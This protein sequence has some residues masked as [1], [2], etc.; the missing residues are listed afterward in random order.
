MRKSAWIS[1]VLLTLSLSACKGGKISKDQCEKLIDH[2]VDVIM[3]QMGGGLSDDIKKDA[4]KQAREK[5]AAQMDKCT[6]E[7]TTAQYDC[8]MKADSLDAI[9]KCGDE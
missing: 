3:K 9:M 4:A 7:V 8:A 6:D 2:S 1:A 5:M